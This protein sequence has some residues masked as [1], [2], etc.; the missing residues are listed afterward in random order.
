MRKLQLFITGTDTGVGKTT[1]SALFARFLKDRGLNVGYY[2]PVET[3]CSPECEDVKTLSA[4]TNQPLDEMIVYKFKTPASPLAASYIEGKKVEIGKLV[5]RFNQLKDK[6]DILLVEGAGGI[7]V[8]I[9]EGK[10]KIYTYRDFLSYIKTPVVV[11]ARAGLGTINHTALTCEALK[12]FKVAGI[13]FNFDKNY[14]D[15]ISIHHNTQLV[16]K[17]TGITNTI[18]IPFMEN[19]SVDKSLSGALEKFLR[20]ILC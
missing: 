11:V 13:V 5:D 19:L 8:P 20:E 1:F 14:E 6:Y 18:K 2:K 15:D 3:G 16:Q 12:N 10:N 17:M 4:I 7:L 9:T